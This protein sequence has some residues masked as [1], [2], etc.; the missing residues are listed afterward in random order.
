MTEKQRCTWANGDPLMAGYHD[1]EWGAA[2]FGK[3]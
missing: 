2:P 3:C 1:L